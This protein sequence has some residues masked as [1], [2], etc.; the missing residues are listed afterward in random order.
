MSIKQRYYF[1]HTE[2]FNMQVYG[3]IKKDPQEKSEL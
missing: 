2:K 1:L 3:L